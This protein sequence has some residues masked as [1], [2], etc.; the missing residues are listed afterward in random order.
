[1]NDNSGVILIAV[2]RCHEFEFILDIQKPLV[3]KNTHHSSNHTCQIS[4]NAGEKGIV[5]PRKFSGNSEK[6]EL[7]K[8]IIYCIT[9]YD[10]H[11]LMHLI[12]I[13]SMMKT[14]MRS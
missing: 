8:M 9:S 11:K 10:I 4:V 7:Y 1:M 2:V 6:K 13:I 14:L 12:I 5:H 3:K